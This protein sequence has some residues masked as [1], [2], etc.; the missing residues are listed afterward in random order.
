MIS[1][2]ANLP[3]LLR[4]LS[5]LP[6]SAKQRGLLQK[7]G[8]FRVYPVEIA[9]CQLQ[10]WHNKHVDLEPLKRKGFPVLIML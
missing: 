9:M 4:E 2:D 6:L 7:N 8:Y 3:A 1:Q 5:S 10:G